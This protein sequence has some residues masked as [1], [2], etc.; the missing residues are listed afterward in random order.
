MLDMKFVLG[1]EF[2]K[3]FVRIVDVLVENFCS[4]VMVWLG[5]DYEVLKVE[6]LYLIY[7]VIL[8]FG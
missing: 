7:C 5:L 1:K 4:G 8:G 2:L 3:E 6:N